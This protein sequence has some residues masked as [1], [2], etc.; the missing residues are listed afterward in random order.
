[1][2]HSIYVLFAA[3]LYV[4]GSLRLI[5]HNEIVFYTCARLLLFIYMHIYTKEEAA[6]HH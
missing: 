6:S 5:I 3:C 2:E 4:D 1:V